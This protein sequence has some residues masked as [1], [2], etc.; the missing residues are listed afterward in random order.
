MYPSHTAS[1]PARPK[2]DAGIIPR[3][4]G[5]CDAAA[6]AGAARVICIGWAAWP[7]E[8]L[9][10]LNTPGDAHEKAQNEAIYDAPNVKPPVQEFCEPARTT[11]YQ[12][13]LVR[14]R[15]AGIKSPAAA[16]DRATLASDPS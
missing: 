11:R 6:S 3:R 4:C 14:S 16:E 8:A 5:R 9:W 2:H 7:V 10:Q 12:L 1:T 13:W 15:Q